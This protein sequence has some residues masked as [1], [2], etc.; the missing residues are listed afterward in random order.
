[1]L[2]CLKVGPLWQL[3]LLWLGSCS[4]AGHAQLFARMAEGLKGVKEG[5]PHRWYVRQQPGLALDVSQA[6][7]H[8]QQGCQAA[9]HAAA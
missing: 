9:L 1:M 5:I 2:L 8:V 6:V 3:L 4:T 7:A